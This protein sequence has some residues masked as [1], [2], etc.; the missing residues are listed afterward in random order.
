M[1]SVLLQGK[2]VALS[3]EFPEV[4]GQALDFL[5]VNKKLK[6]VSLQTFSGRK[7]LIYSVPSLDTPV[8]ATTTKKLNELAAKSPDLAVLVVSA[9]LPF[10]MGRFCGSEKLKNLVPLST[11]RSAQFATDYGLLISEGPL[12]GLLAR[13][14]LVLDE[15]NNIV[16]ARLTDDIASEPDFD[17]ALAAVVED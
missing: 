7:K 10:A 17:A 2:A 12:A 9:D 16:F 1:A 4:G 6:D 11:M 13:A 14:L 5:L 3:G 8:C 15:A